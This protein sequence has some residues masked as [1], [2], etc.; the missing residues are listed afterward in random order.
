[1]WL[2]DLFRG[3]CCA[4]FLTFTSASIDF[5]LAKAGQR[6]ETFAAALGTVVLEARRSYVLSLGLF[7]LAFTVTGG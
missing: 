2:L 5:H 7:M 6:A 1:M 3:F 4:L